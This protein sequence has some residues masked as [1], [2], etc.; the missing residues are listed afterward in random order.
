VPDFTTTGP[1]SCSNTIGTTVAITLLTGANTIQ[2]NR[3]IIDQLNVN[4]E[5]SD[6][7]TPGAAIADVAVVADTAPVTF[8][9]DGT[10][11]VDLAICSA[12][13]LAL[14]GDLGL[15][16]S[17]TL[18]ISSSLTLAAC[19]P[20]SGM[21][22][23]APSIDFQITIGGVS[24]GDPTVTVDTSDIDATTALFFSNVIN[25]IQGTIETAVGAIDDSVI[26][27]AVNGAADGIESLI[28]LGVDAVLPTCIRIG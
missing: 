12:T 23:I 5:F 9:A 10:L 6:F 28:Q 25:Q 11:T 17:A 8:G 26:E 27:T 13:S 3:L 4:G 14:N 16:L 1:A 15:A 20:E 19:T 18:L 21:Y 2:L 7:A 24:L 22:A